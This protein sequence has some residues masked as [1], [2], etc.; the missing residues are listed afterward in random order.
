VSAE[1]IKSAGYGDGSEPDKHG[2]FRCSYCLNLV[3]P[4]LPGDFIWRD[5]S[6]EMVLISLEDYRKLLEDRKT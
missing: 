2:G 1:P 6:G 4:H 5:A 3:H